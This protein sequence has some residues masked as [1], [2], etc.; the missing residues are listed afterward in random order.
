MVCKILLVG[1]GLTSAVT[2]SLLRKMCQKHVNLVF[3]DKAKEVG[4]RMRTSMSPS[5]SNSIADLGAQYITSTQENF[6]NHSDL[7]ESLILGKLLEPLCSKIEGMKDLPVGTKQFVAPHGMNSLVKHFL[8]NAADE[9]HFGYYVVSISKQGKRWLVETECGVNDMFDV[10]ILTLPVPQLL[11]IGG[12]IQEI[13]HKNSEMKHSLKSVTF[14]SRY[15]LCLFFDSNFKF[16]PG[17]DSKY[18]C[19]N[20]IFRF[21]SF[22]NKKRNRP[23]LPSAVVFHTSIQYGAINSDRE[24]NDVKN[25]LVCHVKEMFPDWPEPEH[26]ECQR[27]QYSQVMTPY[28]GQPGCLTIEQHPLL[29]AGG[30]S[31]MSSH[32]DGCISSAFI[33]ADTVGL[34]I[35]KSEQN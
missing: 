27:W 20:E 2:G 21:V 28:L 18:I 33:L 11:D 35:K 5:N 4:G 13:I 9:I 24:L 12:F 7:Y 30:D 32:I 8:Y 10:V 31:F 6:T 19:D 16:N 29:V 25:E 34:A 3:W 22:D 15:A 14:S 23:D 1:T 17:W 26:I